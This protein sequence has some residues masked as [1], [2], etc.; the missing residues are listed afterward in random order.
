MK[1]AIGS[2][3]FGLNYGISNQVGKVSNDAL[4]NILEYC[5]CNSIDL[6]DTA[7]AYGDAE[8]RLGN[9]G[10]SSFS[11]ITKIPRVPAGVA[12]AKEWVRAIFFSSLEK[13]KVKK[14]Y[15]VLIHFPS[16]LLEP[17]G[18]SIYEALYKLKDAGFI[19]K[20]GISTYDPDECRQ[21]M[22]IFP[23]SIVQAPLNLVDRRFHESGC[24]DEMANAG[25]EVHVRSVYLQGLLL[26]PKE[27]IP[28][29]FSEWKSFFT[30]WDRW[31]KS[32]GFTPSQACLSFIDQIPGIDRVVIGV[33]SVEQISEVNV[34]YPRIT[35]GEFPKI[36]NPSERLI[37][38][39]TW[40]RE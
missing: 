38:P 11:L 33:E 9:F 35:V 34:A 39:S 5:R 40:I 30:N 4:E 1:L 28:S 18:V 37:N 32:S 16:Q 14:V 6:I 7:M 29:Q 36:N 31:V 19:S 2:A 22:K 8:A 26:M 17:I 13:L 23:I 3:Q 24:I 15:G 27:M 21:L 10:V 20:I 12:D 25:I